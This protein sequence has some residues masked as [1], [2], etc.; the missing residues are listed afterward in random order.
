MMLI[1]QNERLAKITGLLL[2]FMFKKVK[3][4]IQEQKQTVNKWG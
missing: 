2:T 1:V 3:I 4:I